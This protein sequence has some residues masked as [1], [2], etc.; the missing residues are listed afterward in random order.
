MSSFA[1][2]KARI[3]SMAGTNFWVRY[4]TLA[5]YRA[6]C[7][8]GVSLTRFSSS[9]HHANLDETLKYVDRIFN[10]Y[11]F[12]AGVERFYG[13]AVEVGPGDLSGVGLM[14]LA[15]GC[16]QVDLINRFKTKTDSVLQDQVNRTI[17]SKH[18]TVSTDR[19]QHHCGKSSAAE[20]FFRQN[21]GYDFIL[22][23]AVLEHVYD[24]VAAIQSM[25]EALNPGGTMVH[26]VGSID[27]GQFSDKFHDL[28]YLRLPALLYAPLGAAGGPNRVYSSTYSAACEAA[29][30]EHKRYVT[31]LSGFTDLLPLGMMFDDIAPEMLSHS[32]QHVAAIRPKL[33]KP[34]RSMTD[35]DLMV[36]GFTIVARK[37]NA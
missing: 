30:L 9:G 22:S 28:S 17:L 20:T 18:P 13:R 26:I 5:S 11:K 23:A 36:S 27:H 6:V 7:A 16:S 19:L 2:A 1:V 34:F 24:P 3:K 31:L 21:R 8:A 29:G 15:N 33:A 14:L 25:A 4:A 32:R 12:Y 10:E 35:E 37:P